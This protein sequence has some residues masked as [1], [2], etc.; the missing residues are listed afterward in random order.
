MMKYSG[1]M[2]LKMNDVLGDRTPKTTYH[3][4]GNRASKSAGREEI[5]FAGFCS[6][7]RLVFYI[8]LLSDKLAKSPHP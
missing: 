2:H 3:I 1:Q 6:L 4:L 5:V 8:C 7:T